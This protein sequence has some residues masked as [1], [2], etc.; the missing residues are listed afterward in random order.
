M[1][2]DDVQA[3]DD[4]GQGLPGNGT[5]LFGVQVAGQVVTGQGARLA[6]LGLAGAA[7]RSGGLHALVS[8]PV[9]G[10]RGLSD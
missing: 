10:P 3:R 4:L 7:D 8:R 6:R 5:G 9:C 2:G 1:R